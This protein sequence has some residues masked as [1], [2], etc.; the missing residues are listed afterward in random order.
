[1]TE[2]FVVGVSAGDDDAPTTSTLVVNSTARSI[3][4]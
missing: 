3:F 1:M 4:C 2:G